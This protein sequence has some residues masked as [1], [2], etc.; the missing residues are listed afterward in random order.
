VAATGEVQ[1]HH[2]AGGALDQGADRGAV[3]GTHDQ[4]AFPMAR[5]GTIGDLGWA[6]RDHHHV[7][8]HP[9]ARCVE[10]GVRVST[11]ASGAQAGRQLL[12]QC[13]ASLH[14]D[15]LIDRLVGHRHRAIMTELGAQSRGDLLRRPQLAQI[16][17]DA[18]RQRRVG[19]QLGQLRA[20]R[21]VTCLA[22]RRHRL[23]AVTPGTTAHFAADR[24]GRPTQLGRDRTQRAATLDPDS[25]RDPFL[26]R[27]APS[28]AS[29]LR[30]IPITTTEHPA[31]R[32]QHVGDRPHR[33]ID[34][35]QNLLVSR[36]LRRQTNDLAT[37]LRRQPIPTTPHAT[38]PLAQ[39]IQS[40]LA[41]GTAL[42]R[43]PEINGL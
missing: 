31:E 7:R 35:L 40:S 12:A 13:A 17:T 41:K 29:V 36:T 10:S 38:H 23:I 25:N 1:E 42:H 8:Q 5:H 3:A 21:P 27:Q 16:G 9:P 15:R 34:L 4:V 6:L 18:R 32:T 43:P 14:V 39:V 20:T 33:H 2:E 28:Q 19:D 22:M 30:R 26:Q 37:H 11:G 24:R